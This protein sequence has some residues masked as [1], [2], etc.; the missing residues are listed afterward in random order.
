MAHAEYVPPD[1]TKTTPSLKPENEM[2]KRLMKAGKK[3][4]TYR[5]SQHALDRQEALQ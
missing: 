2:Q 4:Q 1:G 5:L 3:R